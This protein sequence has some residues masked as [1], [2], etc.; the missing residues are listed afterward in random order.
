VKSRFLL[1][2]GTSFLL[3][4]PNKYFIFIR[5]LFPARVFSHMCG[6][7]SSSGSL[8]V[9][10][11]SIAGS[12]EL[13]PVRVYLG[14]KPFILEVSDLFERVPTGDGGELCLLQIQ[15]NPMN[16]MD[17]LD[18]VGDLLGGCAR[19]RGCGGRGPRRPR[20]ERPTPPG[21]ALWMPRGR[22]KH[23]LHGAGRPAAGPT[24]EDLL[25]NFW[26][27]GGVFLQKFVTILDFEE[28]RVGF[29]EPARHSILP[30]FDQQQSAGGTKT[31]AAEPSVHPVPIHVG[32]GQPN[33]WQIGASDGVVPLSAGDHAAMT[34]GHLP[35]VG[36]TAP[37]AGQPDRQAPFPWAVVML[38]AGLS[39]V[40]AG[41]T[42]ITW[43]LKRRKNVAAE[44]TAA[45][46][47]AGEAEEDPMAAE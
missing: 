33:V 19:G 41:S 36:S 42:W 20:A 35:P 29:A 9:C 17:P 30:A 46:P 44:T 37:V 28:G 26:V 10:N 23:A 12:K 8:V 7:D 22:A 40:A 16:S 24:R 2:T 45:E 13:L 34:G 1:D 43:K 47:Q 5:S 27:I 18:I 15:Q 31:T 11:C 3:A 4:P 39:C 21:G 6:L 25:D 14:G 38:G 32:D